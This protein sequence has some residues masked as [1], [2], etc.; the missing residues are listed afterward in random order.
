M[1]KVNDE[2]DS[3]NAPANQYV[4]VRNGAYYVAG[5]RIGLDVIVCE[6]RDG[7]SP[8]EIFEAYPSIGSLS[9]LYGALTFV[10]E[11]PGDIDSYLK[12]QD[13]RWEAFKVR[14]PLSPDMIERFERA[15]RELSVRNS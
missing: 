6:F 5:T 12:A 13:E 10:L 3:D 14:Y 2:V 7:R 11:H 1:A 8:E 9:K 4:E 15:K